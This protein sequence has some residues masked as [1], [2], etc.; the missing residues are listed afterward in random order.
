MLTTTRICKEL[1]SL[2]NTLFSPLTCSVV[3]ALGGGK[4][5]SWHHQGQAKPDISYSG[6][7]RQQ[8][9]KELS[10]IP[11]WAEVTAF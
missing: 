1:H 7:T 9:E 4:G 2:Q 6:E 3:T 10:S 11:I 5:R 8:E